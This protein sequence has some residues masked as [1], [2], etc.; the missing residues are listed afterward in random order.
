MASSSRT[1]VAAHTSTITANDLQTF[2]LESTRSEAPRHIES[3][4]LPE[5]ATETSVLYDPQAH[6]LLRVI[7]HRRTVELISL[8]T[9]VSPIRFTFPAPVLPSPAV[10]YDDGEIH[11]IAC[12]QAGSVFRLVFP[13]PHLWNTQYMAKDWREEYFLR[14][15]TS[16]LLGPVHVKEAGCLFIALK[17]GGILQLDASRRL[18]NAEFQGEIFHSA[19]AT[20]ESNSLA[21]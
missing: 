8:S 15:P 14:H 11:V 1:L 21:P 17:D 16:N 20:Y 18:G 3:D 19:H 5:H 7:H 2:T 10:V 13:L 6:I 9:D 4:I 12:T